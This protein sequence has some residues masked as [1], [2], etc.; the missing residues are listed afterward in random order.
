[1][2][3]DFV[4]NEVLVHSD[5]L[6][7]YAN[8]FTKDENEAKDLL[9]ETLIKVFRYQ[10]NYSVGTNLLGWMYTIMRSI[11]LNACRKKKIEENYFKNIKS[12]SL[13]INNSAKNKGENSFVREDI[14]KV[15]QSLP[16]KYIEAFVM[17]FEGYKYYEIAEHFN[18]PEGTIK[19]RIHTA[20][21][22][23]QRKLSNYRDINS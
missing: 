10:K 7:K 9:Q 20:R 16:E 15:M 8:R 1:M 21:K 19:T 23:L 13:V 5:T 22:L 17:Y 4:K 14:L 12:F 11:F 6:L 3:N 2:N 18:V